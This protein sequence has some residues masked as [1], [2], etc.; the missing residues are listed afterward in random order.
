MGS[1]ETRKKNKCIYHF[2]LLSIID[3]D[4]IRLNIIGDEINQEEVE[5]EQLVARY[6]IKKKEQFLEF[7]FLKQIFF[8]NILLDIINYIVPMLLFYKDKEIYFIKIQ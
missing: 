5:T 8:Q 3:S 1:L 2:N 7:V 6:I 4:L